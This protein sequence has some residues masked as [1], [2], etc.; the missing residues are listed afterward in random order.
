MNYFKNPQMVLKK[1][2]KQTKIS[3]GGGGGGVVGF[4]LDSSFNSAAN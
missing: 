1:K 4:E 3:G 2:Q